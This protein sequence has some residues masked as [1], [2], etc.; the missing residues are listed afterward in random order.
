MEAAAGGLDERS[1]REL[2]T[3]LNGRSALRSTAQ[4]KFQLDRYGQRFVKGLAYYKAPST[5]SADKVKANKTLAPAISELGLR[6]SKFLG[7]DE[8]QSVQLLQCYLQDD[9]RGTQDSIKLVPQDE[10]QSQALMLKM[11]DYYYEERICMLRCVRHLLTYFQDDK[12][13]Y[14]EQFG[15]CVEMLHQNDII[16]QYRKQLESL[17]KEDAPTWETHGNI[18]TERQ[19]SRW[20]VQCLRE[21]T[22]L[23]EIT[24]LYYAYFLM[25]PS[26]LLAFTKLFKE[27]GFGLRQQNRHLVEQSMDPLVER[28]GYFSVLIFLEAID[29]DSLQDCAFRD[30]TKKHPFASEKQVCKDI[31]NVLLTFGDLPHHAPVLLAWALLRHT[32]SSDEAETAI[33]KMGNTAIQLH[34]FQYLT[35]MLKSLGSS[36]HNCT[37]STACVCIY[38]LLCFVLTTLEEHTLGKQQD[39]IDTACQVFSAPNL[40]DLFWNTE[41]S[42]GLG[43]LLDSAVG[44]FP[45]R[46]SPLL[47]LLTALVSKSSVKKVY[48]FLDKMSLY[49]EHFKHKP[50]DVITHEDGTLWKRKSPKHLYALGTGQTNLNIPQGAIGQVISNER[51]FVIRWDFCYSS[52]TLFTCEIEMLLHVVSTA[53][54]IQHCQRVKPILDLVHK[55]ISADPSIADYLL[56]ITSRIYMLLQRLTTVMSPPMDFISSCVKCL[57]VLATCIPAKVWADLHHTG[58]LPFAPNP[59]S[60]Q[61]MSEGMNAGGYGTLL[62][63]EQSQGEYAVTISFL[64]LVTTLVKSQLGSTQSQGLVPCILF[65][66]REMLP[67]YH[68]WRY[69]THG[70]RE[71]L[72]CMILG[73]IH[74]ILNLSD[75]TSHSSAP[76]LQSL[77]IF[78]LTNTEAGQAVINIM[79]IG[80]DTI[81]TVMMSQ[82]GSSDSEGQGQMLIQTVKLAFSITNNVIRLKPPAS[83]IS[84]LEQALT[85]H[86]AHGNNLIA[87]LAKYIY[88]KFDPSLPRLAIQL[89][90]R[91]ATVSPM[92]VYA[93]LGSDAAAIRDAFLIRLQCSIEDLQIKVMILEFL[94][95]AVETQPGLI[96]LFLNLELTN[97][98][99]GSKE[100]SLGKWSCLQVVLNLID[101]QKSERFWSTPQLHRSAIAFLHAIWQDR[102]DS[103]MTVLRT[104]PNFWENL[105]SPLFGTLVPPSESSELSVLETCAFIMRIICLEIFH[106]VRGFMDSALKGVL[107]KFSEKKRFKYWSE[108]V[109]SLVCRE[110][111]AEGSCASPP[112]YQML[113][114][115]WRMFLIIAAN[116]AEVMHLTDVDVQQQLFHQVLNDTQTLLLVPGS[117]ACVQLGS[118]L[119]TLMIIL[120]RKWRK[121][122]GSPEDILPP[123]TQ[124]LEGILQ[125]DSQQM[126]KTKSRVFSALIY[127]LEI[128][129]MKASEIPQ[130]EQLVLNV[131]TTLQNE[132]LVLNDQT[133]VALKAGDGVEDKDSMETEE[134]PRMQQ[135]DQRDGVCV[136]ALYLAKELCQADEDGEQWLHVIRKLPVLPMLFS[137]LEVSLQ[138]KQNLH[139]C[140]ATLHLLFTLAKTHQG[141]SAL[142]GAGV[143]QSVCLPLLS[144]YQQSSNGVGST[145]Q[146]AMSSRKILD[147]PSWPGVY[148]L[149]VSL[150]ERLLKTLRYNFLREALDF[151]GVHQ[152]RILQCLS[153][154][155]TVQSLA[156]LE[157]A[158]HT[159]GFLLQLS[160]FTNEWHFHLPQ[161]MKDIEVNLCYLCQ[162]CTS[163]LHSRKM[164]QH[165]LQIKNGEAVAQTTTPRPFRGPQTP[166]KQP[167]AET[168]ALEFKALRSVQYSLLKILSKT[169]ASLRAF[170]PDLCHILQVQPLDLAQFHL[171]FS[172]NFT[173]PAFDTDVTPSFGTLLA[174]VNVMLN[175]LG[176]KD[177]PILHQ[178]S[179]ATAEENKN[180]KY[181][182]LFTMENCF[183]LLISQAVRYLRDPS[184]NSRDKQ[185]MKQELSSELST[186]LSSLHRFF[187]RGGPSSPAGGH[188]PSPQTRPLTS[189][190]QEPLIQLVQAFV[191]HVQR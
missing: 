153:A 12:Y 65:V 182:Q 1:S 189:S 160:N 112:E 106:V 115:A 101:F 179:F 148:R 139:F 23:L 98:S 109:H 8:E 159:V 108:Y 166:S 158:D 130:Y 88:H 27:Q 83:G 186:L 81:N 149:T 129:Q 102:R 110:A 95:V 71:Q 59:V 64:R 10:R 150:M 127:V 161:L 167:T 17:F 48:M 121:A 191:Q 42:M 91:L 134:T 79:G 6:I 78:S 163:L 99:D 7:L 84:P 181:L 21:Q 120:L 172:L 147:A 55:V 169:L 57:T 137:A 22:M 16:G 146:P 103:A 94:T 128:K 175:M 76:N 184:V 140:E 168:E 155:R 97:A 56:P 39:V 92:S 73:L 60:G 173:T 11:A 34:V 43:V 68:R 185:R 51:G 14:R 188:L 33:R 154:V 67:N 180:M 3:I 74:A 70:V 183:Y 77:C 119:C 87:V 19:V 15:E 177:L 52:W 80:V 164:L 122:M 170:T 176:E 2:W 86:G 187:R 138:V 26:E 93:C 72:G 75:D 123:L 165:Y 62:G 89:L 145:T 114:S 125:I 54:V 143:A 40:S 135:K 53:D 47:Q 4:I 9:Y 178:P 85:Q 18:M 36:E 156:C 20:F 141:A 5:S 96:E 126:E 157:E 136:L 90:K 37:S 63:I 152:D 162:S 32:L 144:V 45:N 117:V 49:T 69:N 190:A 105:T 66:L 58:F 31:D 28:I 131:C 30:Q 107:K 132:V 44:I 151:V 142:A 25:S 38:S 82:A 41:P 118:M 35:N 113:I 124:I 174:T 104:K 50:H 171:L 24:F 46:L 133:R 61:I 13:P 116:N 29:I 111:E 100:Y